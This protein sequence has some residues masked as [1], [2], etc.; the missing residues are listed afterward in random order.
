MYKERNSILKFLFMARDSH[1]YK[2]LPYVKY[3]F[4]SRPSVNINISSKMSDC[5]VI[6]QNC[7]I[8]L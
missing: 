5:K 8:P 6:E 2:C 3:S 1:I 7:L 4:V